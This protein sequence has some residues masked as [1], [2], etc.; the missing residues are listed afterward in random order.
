MNIDRFTQKSIAA[1]QDAQRLSKEYGNQQIDQLH[2]LAAVCGDA[3]GLVPQLLTAMGVDAQRFLAAV[4]TELEKLPKVRSYGSEADKIYVSPDVDKALQSA[5]AV[6]HT[7]PSSTFSWVCWT[8]PRARRR[9]CSA[10][11]ISRRTG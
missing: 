5:E 8:R 10:A 4:G 1:I 2:L 6:A 3:E 7:S 11:S 9:S